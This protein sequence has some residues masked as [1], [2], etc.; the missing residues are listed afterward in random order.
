MNNLTIINQTLDSREVAEMCEMNHADLL[1]KIKGINDSL[2]KSKIAFTSL[3][4]ENIYND[5]Q[6]KPR[7]KFDITKHGCDFLANKLTGD[8]GNLFTFKYVEK[9]NHMEQGIKNDLIVNSVKAEITSLINDIVSQK[10]EQIEEKCSEYFR[11]LA[12]QKTNIIKYIKTR[13]GSNDDKYDLVKQR[14]LIKLNATKWEDIP[15][16]TLVNS[17]NIIDESI[18]IINLDS[19]RQVSIWG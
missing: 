9:F 8:K 2:G 12:V 15:V 11:P 3:W 17:L 13:L 10:V 18:R 19:D 7:R 4:T 16:E 14:V 5:N 6:N 1:K